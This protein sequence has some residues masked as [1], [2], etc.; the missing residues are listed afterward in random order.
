[1]PRIVQNNI[2]RNIDEIIL[3][4]LDKGPTEIH[5]FF[6]Y[7]RMLETSNTLCFQHFIHVD[8]DSYF[9]FIPRYFNYIILS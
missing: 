6:A 9:K 7:F 4:W 8:P 3:L 2:D 1:M 5:L